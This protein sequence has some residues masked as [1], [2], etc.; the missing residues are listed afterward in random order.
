[1]AKGGRF[2][3]RSRGSRAVTRMP[4]FGRGIVPFGYGIGVDRQIQYPP[5]YGPGMKPEDIEPQTP[6]ENKTLEYIEMAYDVLR[7]G[8]NLYNALK[9]QPRLAMPENL[10][11]RPAPQPIDPS[12][13]TGSN[14]E[15][16]K[17]GVQSA[18]ESAR[19][20]FSP[21]GTSMEPV[22]LEVVP[23]DNPETSPSAREYTGMTGDE[24]FTEDGKI[25]AAQMSELLSRGY[26]LPTAEELRQMGMGVFTDGQGRVTGYTKPD[27]T[28]IQWE[29]PN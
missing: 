11:N 15:E 26:S 24:M 25:S 13:V 14:A 3:G 21:T 4:G 12:T 1:M 8:V 7:G 29:Y 16:V 17:T 9:G 20:A 19:D 2:A 5:S 27:G 23:I 28:T 10:V 22:P 6:E 18:F